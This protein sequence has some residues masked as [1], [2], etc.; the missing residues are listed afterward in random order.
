VR[1]GCVLLLTLALSACAHRP[2]PRI[3]TVEVPV[4]IA[5]KCAADPGP[6]PTYPD[7]D[8]ALRAAPNIF[9]RTKLLLAGR[10][11]RIGREGELEAAV[12]GC[13]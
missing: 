11:L 9:E 1:V 6:T 13:R 8:A 7:S 4:P 10:K 3:E 2:E 12:S 5:V